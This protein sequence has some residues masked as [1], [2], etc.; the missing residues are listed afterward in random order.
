MSRHVA[1]DL[2]ADSG[3][4]IAGELR[5][6]ILTTSDLARFANAPLVLHDGLRWNL[7]ALYA[8]ALEGLTRAG[9]SGENVASISV[10]SW[11]VDYVYASTE[12]PLLGLP[13]CY[14]DKRLEGALE[15]AFA[16]VSSDE[17]YAETGVQFMVYNTLYQLHDDTVRRPRLTGLAEC[18]LP[19]AD[20]LNFLLCG[21]MATDRSMASTTQLFNPRHGAWSSFLPER[22]GI[23]RRLL[24]RVVPSA[25]VLGPVGSYLALPHLQGTQVVA[26]CSHDTAAAVAAAPGEGQDWA[27]LCS[28]TW[29][30]LG[31]ELD[32]PLISADS[33]LANF[34]NE[35]GAENTVRFLRNI[36]G[37]WILQECRR[38]WASASGAPPDHRILM[39]EATASPPLQALINTGDPRFLRPGS[40][41]EKIRSYCRETGQPL[42]SSRGEIARCILESLALEYAR[43]LRELETLAGRTMRRLHLV[44]GGSRNTLLNQLTADACGV[45]VLA[46]PAEATA[47]GNI[48]LQALALGLV[49]SLAHLREIVRASFPLARFLPQAGG[50][51]TWANARQ[52]HS[53]L[54]SLTH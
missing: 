8:G 24:P 47:I 54:P 11:A 38:E 19:I 16:L 5:N 2:G 4:V 34:T 18:I 41:P 44:G 6:G 27:Y 12:E 52:I 46:G 17:I 1:I 43:T 10:D 25:T 26:S 32:A 37:L 42:P 48:L 21:H 13:Y 40:M 22:L 9:G 35:L 28:G 15:R 50:A 49:R 7:P 3:R 51:K 33:R 14:R 29:S 45:E 36:A 20:H 30:L 53:R 39:E 23:S 31:V